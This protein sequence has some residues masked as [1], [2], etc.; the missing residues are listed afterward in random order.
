MV[1]SIKK[2]I[3]GD[4]KY[5]IVN[6]KQ[7]I[8]NITLELSKLK[9][10]ELKA[11]KMENSL[12]FIV[13]DRSGSMHALIDDIKASSKNLLQSYLAKYHEKAILS[14]IAFDD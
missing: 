12:I 3:L 13:I 10:Q 1:E 2:E 4:I 6:E 5:E 14:V 7:A 8:L 11:A 9:Y